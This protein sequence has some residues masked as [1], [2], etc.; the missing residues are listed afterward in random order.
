MLWNYSYFL[1]AFHYVLLHISQ[2]INESI[3]YI[4][5][6]LQCFTFNLNSWSQLIFN[7]FINY[8]PCKYSLTIVV[9]TLF[10]KFLIIKLLN[11]FLID[12]I[13][14]FY[15]R[16]NQ[17]SGDISFG[18]LICSNLIFLFIYLPNFLRLIKVFRDSFD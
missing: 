14:F 12:C 17:Q 3:T 11:K 15:L 8:L 9:V 18:N 5:Y 2:N 10:L 1:L 6:K 16:T 4:R 13:L 7:N